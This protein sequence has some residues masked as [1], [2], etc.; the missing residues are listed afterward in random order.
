MTLRSPT[1]TDVSGALGRGGY[2]GIQDDSD[3]NI[4]IVED[5]GGAD[6]DGHARRSGRTAS[7]TATCRRT[8]ATCERQAPGAPGAERG[9]HPITFESQ[10]ALN[11]PDQVALRTYGRTFNTRWVTIHDTAVDGN[12]AVQRQH[13]REDRARHTV[14]APG[15]RRSSGPG[16]EL[17]GVLLR[18]DGRHDRNEPRERR[19]GRRGGGGWLD[20]QAR[21]ERPVVGHRQALALLQGNESVAGL[22]NVTFI[23]H[24]QIAFV[25]DAGDTLHTP[26]EGTRLRLRLRRDDGLLNPARSRCGSS[27]RAATR[28]R[29]STPA[30]GGFGKNEGDNEIT[31][32]HVSDGDPDVGGILGAKIPKLVQR[33]LALVLDPAARRQLH[34]GDLGS[35][36]GQ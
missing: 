25:E 17:Q 5:I 10:A 6:Q 11:A 7:S 3:G 31:G 22:D 18:R 27:P 14:Q 35:D 2:E 32:I 9:G 1:V 13:A 34:V 19:P 15:E 36:D 30:N 23:S 28:R 8:R 16:D 21:P 26:A 29:R 20:L 33:R 24:D 12:D 4:W